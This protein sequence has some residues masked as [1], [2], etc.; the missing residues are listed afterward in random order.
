MG[1]SE[2]DSNTIFLCAITW[3]Q[4][5]FVGQELPWMLVYTPKWEKQGARNIYIWQL[6]KLSPL[7]VCRWETPHPLSLLPQRMAA[8]SGAE[9]GVYWLMVLSA[10]AGWRGL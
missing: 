5:M 4:I 6:A 10:S 9:G 3:G 7:P 2:Q 8:P 1:M